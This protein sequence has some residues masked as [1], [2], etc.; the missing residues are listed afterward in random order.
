VTDW[1]AEPADALAGLARVRG[2]KNP[3]LEAV[4]RLEPALDAFREL[5]EAAA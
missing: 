5:L 1:C 3:D 2:T 4:R